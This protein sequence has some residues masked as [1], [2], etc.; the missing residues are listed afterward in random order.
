MTDDLKISLTASVVSG[1][2][3]HARLVWYLQP[4]DASVT[5]LD[6]FEEVIIYLRGWSGALPSRVRQP[7]GSAADVTVPNGRRHTKPR[8]SLGREVRNWRTKVAKV[9][10]DAAATQSGINIQTWRG[11]EGQRKPS[12]SVLGKL[13]VVMGRSVEELRALEASPDPS[14]VS[15][16]VTWPADA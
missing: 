16:A 7:A 2:N 13:A 12:E 10:Q 1:L 3:G 14:G 4:T 5:R 15:S 8:S 11:I 9:T 6:A